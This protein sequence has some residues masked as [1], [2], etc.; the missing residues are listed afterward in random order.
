MDAVEPKYRSPWGRAPRAPFGSEL[1]ADALE[2]FGP[3]AE[4]V[5]CEGALASLARRKIA[6]GLGERAAV[7]GVYSASSPDVGLP[8]DLLE[9]RRIVLSLDRDKYGEAAREKLAA[10]LGGI[11]GELVHERT[12]G[13]AVDAGDLLEAAR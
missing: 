11:A 4:I 1:L 8:M 6:R 9:G 2:W 12:R 5:V 13:D 3:D 10:L 7:I